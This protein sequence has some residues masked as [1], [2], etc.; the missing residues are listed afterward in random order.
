MLARVTSATCAILLTAC[1]TARPP[2]SPTAPPVQ[3]LPAFSA[4]LESQLDS[5]IM[6]AIA[7]RGTPGAALAVGRHGHTAILKGYGRTD[8]REGAPA[9]EPN[10]IYDLASLTKV[11]ATTTAA[12]ILEEEG[13]LELDRT[14][15][16]YI[17]EFNAPD[18]A[19][20]TVRQLVAHRAGFEPFAPLWEQHSGRV[21]YLQAINTRPLQYPPGTRAVYSDWSPI[22]LGLVIERIAGEP[23]DAFTH[24]RIFYPLGMTS[25]MFLPPD[26]LRP[27]I[28]PTEMRADSTHIHG[29]VHDPNAY[30]LGGV[31]GHAGLFGSA[32]DLAIFAQMLLNGGYFEGVRLLRPETI[33]RWTAKSERGA[34]RAFGWDTPSPGS[35]AGRYFSP[36]SFGHTGF[37]GTSLWIDPQKDLYVVLLTNAV[38]PTRSHSRHFQLRR[39]VADAVQAAVPGERLI[40]WEIVQ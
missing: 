30:A 10:T 40:H 29:F 12:M 35:S 37:T 6:R 5:I 34:S 8:W 18:K 25:T 33:A 26:T 21:A 19:G 7:E 32:R 9:V 4:E 36:R 13:R 24:R 14:V 16:S 20:I 11:V 39:E 22:V 23:L 3:A 38:N 1:A 15:V 28:A 31:A 17:P 2:R 27:R